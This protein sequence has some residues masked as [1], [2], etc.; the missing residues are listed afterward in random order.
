MTG[1]PFL[2]VGLG[3]LGGFVNRLTHPSESPSDLLQTLFSEFFG[4][5]P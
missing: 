5:R 2:A 4:G 1:S 3:F